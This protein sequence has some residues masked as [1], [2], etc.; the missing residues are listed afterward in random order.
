MN[1]AKPETPLERADRMIAELQD[2]GIRAGKRRS[3]WFTQTGYNTRS[4]D[5]YT[6]TFFDRLFAQASK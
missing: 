2:D 5:S 6:R 4:L 1:H 3:D